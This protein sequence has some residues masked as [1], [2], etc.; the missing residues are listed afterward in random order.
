MNEDYTMRF[1]TLLIILKVLVA[2]Y[3]YRFLVVRVCRFG[4]IP[5]TGKLDV[6][7]RVA[8]HIMWTPQP[9]SYCNT[10]GQIEH[11]LPFDDL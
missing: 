10:N 6:M 8:V 11:F 7:S 2:D 1:W 9:A 5:P 3:V 4:K